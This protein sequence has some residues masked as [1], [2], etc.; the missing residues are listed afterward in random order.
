MWKFFWIIVII[1]AIKPNSVMALDYEKASKICKEKG[2]IASTREYWDCVDKQRDIKEQKKLTN[3]DK[4]NYN[5][6]QA[7]EMA[8]R[9]QMRSIQAQERANNEKLKKQYDQNNN[10]KINYTTQKR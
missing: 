7:Q 9:A 5:E 2:F 3:K 1:I 10:N 8:F 6:K 4:P